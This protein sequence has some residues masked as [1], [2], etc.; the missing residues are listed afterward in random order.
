MTKKTDNKVSNNLKKKKV[1]RNDKETDKMIKF[2]LCGIE[3]KKRN[4][5]KFKK[6]QTNENK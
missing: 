6:K 1:W 2:K 3:K 5:L 4:W